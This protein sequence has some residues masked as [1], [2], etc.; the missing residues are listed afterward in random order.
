MGDIG[1]DVSVASGDDFAQPAVV[2]SDN[3]GQ[4]VKLPADPDLSVI[5]PFHQI[6]RFL[7]LGQGKGRKFMGLL[8]S[9]NPVGGDVD[10]RGILKDCAGLL[11]HFFQ[12]VEHGIPFIVGH[13][14]T[15]A[16][17]IG[18]SCRVQG[19]NQFSHQCQSVFTHI[20]L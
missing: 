8:V 20:I 7:C 2:I 3:K 12:T 10:R 5:R 17:V 9:C 18:I 4:T 15:A 6:L 1:A 14:F 13:Q 19:V 11:L 16:A